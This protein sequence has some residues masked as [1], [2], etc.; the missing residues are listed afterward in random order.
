MGRLGTFTPTAAAPITGPQLNYLTSL[1]NELFDLTARITGGDVSDQRTAALAVLTAL[2]KRA[3]SK[4]ISDLKDSTLPTL[5]ATVRASY[6]AQTV[7]RP[8]SEQL[9]TDAIYFTDCQYVRLFESRTGNLYAKVLDIVSRRWEYAPGIV[10][11]VK[12]SDRLTVDQCAALPF[13]WCIRCGAEL[14][15]PV[16][17]ARRMGPVCIQYQM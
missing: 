15:D 5:R 13:S 17:I 16:S 6:S 1:T 8:E 2:D 11:N 3:A 9:D 10:R 12:A 14:S 7:E 4:R